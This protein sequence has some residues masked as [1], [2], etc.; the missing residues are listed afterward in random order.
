MTNVLILSAGRRVELTQRF[1]AARDRLNIDGKVV[2]A[3]ISD[4]APAIYFADKFYL[5]PAIGEENYI[6]SVIDICRKEK[7][8]LIVP[9]IDTELLIL[10]ENREEI[11][12]S[13]GA[14]VLLS[15]NR[16]I[17]ICRDKNNTQD[18][19]EENNFGVPKL[20]THKEIEKGEYSFPLFI[21]PEDGSS[22]I[23]TFK[24]NNAKELKFFSEY[25][26]KP[27]IQEYMSGKEFSIDVFCDFESNPI[28]IVPRER[29]S[30]RSGEIAKGV[31]NKDREI[32]DDVN[33]LISIL[34]P[35]GH[36]T[37]QCMK[38]DEGIKY[39]EINPRFGGG[40]PMS[41]DAGADSCE[42]LYRIL[43]G[44][45]LSYNENYKDGN[46]FLRFD[47]SIMLNENM[48]LCND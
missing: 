3:D 45:K 6:S 27:I 44:E 30:M 12:N 2:A 38:T 46:V 15:D 25:I 26:D 11:E 5:I 9:T 36:I 20:L 19:F 39:I 10:A 34:K 17:K 28:T 13:T 29:I 48:E 8:D 21:K 47:S 23:N 37:I 16:V 4:M 43:R 40:A 24:I 41:I 31:I 18:F 14:K 1:K 22:S 42:N 35:I 33:R 32:I 7:I